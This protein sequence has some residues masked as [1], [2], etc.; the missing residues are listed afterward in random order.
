MIAP[1]RARIRL[2]LRDT[3]AAAAF[4]SV[5]LSG[6]VPAWAMLAF[7]MALAISLVNRRPLS[8][9]TGWSVGVLLVSAV[10]IFGSVFRGG[11]DLVVA[12]CT[13]AFLVTAHR[14]LSAPTAGTDSQVHLTSLLTITGGAALSGELWFGLCLWVFAVAATLSMG[15]LVL[16]GPKPFE[17]DL[18][19][20]PAL[21]RLS[22]G[23]TCALLGG[24]LFFVFFPRLSWNIAGRRATPG[25]GG[26]TG[27]SDRV[28]LG[29]GGD[30]KT[31]PRIVLRAT[32]TP[33][34]GTAQLDQY[35]VGRTFDSFDGRE[36]SGRGKARPAAQQVTL[37]RG[38]VKMID[39]Q[40]ELLPGY[41][42]RTLVALQ[43]PV[44]FSNALTMG[45]SGSQRT[46][47][48]R[49]EN[50]EVHFADAANAYLYH[51]FSL[52]PSERRKP[53]E[54][55]DVARFTHLP[56][57][58]PRVG[59][60]AGQVIKGERDPQAAGALLVSYL[61]REYVYTLELPGEVADPLA[62]FLFERKQGHCEHFATALAVLLR[63]QGFA[64]RV[65]AGFFGGER[66]GD[67]YVVRAGDAH[68]W[69]QVFA[70]G[71]GWVTLDATPDSQ[72]GAQPSA[73]LEWITTAWARLDGLWRSQ[74]VDYTF[75]DQ[76][77]LARSL[78][79]PPRGSASSTEEP[80]SASARLPPVAW[81]AAAAVGLGVFAAARF[82][83]RRRGDR[84]HPASNFL[85]QLERAL[86]KAGIAKL[87]GEAIEEL[88]ARLVGSKHPLGPAVE[89]A[90]RAYL[91]AR[92]GGAPVA[93][94]QRARLLAAI[95]TH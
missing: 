44:M 30:I 8:G 75:Q 90:T 42:S 25:L 74:V 50:E 28:R 78:V 82:L 39:Q 81:L 85:D 76:L 79:R 65:V 40:I 19:V 89:Q 23:V 92:F 18:P 4:A 1:R 68:A 93:A 95:R 55:D 52:A 72:R 22:F 94:A 69:T 67:A 58:D 45:T 87:E 71:V 54:L 88:S 16:E 49:I 14:L 64:A 46:A 11:L 84:A 73:V 26:T 57:I 34:P 27:M 31:S 80:G 9:R 83:S 32:I 48:I 47:L 77:D 35:W 2:L 91:F 21:Q 24:V 63:T 15:L 66:V 56:P 41:D 36:W 7:A 70:P 61:Q 20:R 37:E 43:T 53:Q 33:D 86:R 17:G 38:S 12:S 3:A 59:A 29:G 13:F 10:L 6:A 62:D 51:A 5:A 60:L